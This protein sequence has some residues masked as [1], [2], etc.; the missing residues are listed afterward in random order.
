MNYREVH[1][2]IKNISSSFKCPQCK[3]HVSIPNIKL[4]NIFELVINASENDSIEI[5]NEKHPGK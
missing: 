2:I 4:L 3:K 5:T 1:N